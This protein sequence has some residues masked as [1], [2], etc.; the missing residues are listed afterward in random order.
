MLSAKLPRM[1]IDGARSTLIQVGAELYRQDW[2]PATS[3]N[4]SVRLE[5][6]DLAITAS[7]KHKGRL[8][9][10]DILQVDGNGEPRGPAPARP[11]AETALHVHLYRREPEV[12]AVLHT[13]SVGATVASNRTSATLDF[14]G[15]EI[16]KAFT[17]IDTH[18]S[19]I[20]IPI[21]PN[22]QDMAALS[23]AVDEHMARHGTGVAYLIKGHGLY[24]WGQTMADCQR[25]LEALE[26][27]FEYDRLSR[28]LR[29]AEP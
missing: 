8:Q 11:S 26:Y 21:F 7:G 1:N 27:L 25:H 29:T 9:P 2:V 12:Q 10:E 16:L 19:A 4:F 28:T 22:D 20:S 23:A 18:R 24:T 17:G 3:G 5:S 15:L 6:G 13:H 14:E